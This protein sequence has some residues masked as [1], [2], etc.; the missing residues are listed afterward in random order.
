MDNKMKA[1]A[2][3]RMK[4]LGLLDSAIEAFDKENLVLLSESNNSPFGGALYTLSEA[5][6]AR[7]SAFESEGNR[8]VYHV[9]RSML[10]DSELLS[11]M[12]VSGD[13]EEIW[14]EECEYLKDGEAFAYVINT[15][16]DVCSEFGYIG[17]EPHIGG[18]VRT[19]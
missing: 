4:I 11:L 8:L 15:S 17:I 19:C 2:I 5:Q 13:E 10:G 12:Y 16:D 6:S 9:I 7:V 14:D 18:L 3:R 1:E